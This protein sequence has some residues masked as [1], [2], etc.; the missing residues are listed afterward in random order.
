MTLACT[1]DRGVWCKYRSGNFWQQVVNE[2]FTAQDFRENFRVNKSTFEFLCTELEPAIWKSDTNF[3]EAVTVRERVAIT[4]WRLSTNCDYRTIGHL[5]GVARSTVCII[6][7]AT[8]RAIVDA[9]LQRYIS[10]PAGERLHATIEGFQQMGFPQVGG[11]INGTHIPILGP[12]QYRADYHN[13]E[14]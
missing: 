9:L 8:C 14:G 7:N 5:F 10:F 3:R 12:Q 4:L 2:E 1:I 11:V 13:H 6:V